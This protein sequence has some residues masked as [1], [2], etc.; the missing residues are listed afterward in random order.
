MA[1]NQKVPQKISWSAPEYI[2]YEKSPDWFWALGIITLGAFVSAIILKA[3][4]FSILILLIGFCLALYG[5]RKPKMVNFSVGPMGIEIDDR[6]FDYENLKCFWIEYRPP[7]KKELIIESKKT[8][9]PHISILLSDDVDP[10]KLRA[11]L[12]NF[13]PEEKIEQSLATIIA[14]ILRF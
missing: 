13:L 6:I 5:A 8:F 9:V 12:L 3:F 10:G 4:I 11:L 14:D 7:V 2:F 1:K